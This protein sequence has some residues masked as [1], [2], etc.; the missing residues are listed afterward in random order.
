MIV[1]AE[2]KQQVKRF[3]VI[4]VAVLALAELALLLFAH[5]MLFSAGSLLL[6]FTAFSLLE[7]F[8]PSWVSRVAPKNR[9]GTALG[10][11]SSAQFLGIFVGGLAGGWLYGAY[12][13][14]PVYLF[15]FALAVLWLPLAFQMQT[16]HHSPHTS[17]NQFD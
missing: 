16:P 4:G 6:F 8:L 11:Y 15:C 2:K 14:L 9:K 12:G 1:V 17:K 13:L 7:A 10:I 5:S 3:F